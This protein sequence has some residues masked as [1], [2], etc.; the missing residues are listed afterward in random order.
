VSK[1]LVFWVALLL[2][3]SGGSTLWFALRPDPPARSVAAAADVGESPASEALEDERTLREFEL[4]DQQGRAFSSRE[5]DGQVWVGSFFFS[6]CPSVCV[7]QNQAVEQLQNRYGEKGLKLVSI[8][9]DPQRDTAAT[10]AA[11][12]QRFRAN[13]DQ[14]K[15]LTGDLDYIRRLGREYFLVAVGKEQHGSHLIVFDR[16]GTLRGAFGATNPESFEKCCQLVEELLNEEPAA[17][18]GARPAAPSGAAT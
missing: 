11:Y 4:T 9:C 18:S 8:T 13:V 12:A 17:V 2:V 3:F 15:F 6:S 5:L 10:L 14:W 1:A 16:Q 7:R